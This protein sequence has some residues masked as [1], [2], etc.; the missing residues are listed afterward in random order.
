VQVV[1]KPSLIP[2]RCPD[3]Y[4][5]RNGQPATCGAFLFEAAPSFSGHIIIK[6]RCNKYVE[7]KDLR[8][9]VVIPDYQPA[10][11]QTFRIR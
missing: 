1:P 8:R 7:V 10:N 9:P 2:V 3:V 6:C 5:R 11:A 4:T